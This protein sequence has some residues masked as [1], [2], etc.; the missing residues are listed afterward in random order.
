MDNHAVIVDLD[1][2]LFDCNHRKYLIQGPNPDWDTFFDQARYDTVF[3]YVRN[4][5]VSLQTIGYSML[6]CTSRPENNRPVTEAALRKIAGVS[7]DLLAMRSDSDF[8]PANEVKRDMLGS[9]RK[10]G[11]I[12]IL[13]IED[14]PD[15]VKMWRENGVP[16]LQTPYE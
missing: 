4:T 2:T 11:Y 9:I 14:S 7:W 12:P 8:R 1:G 3:D 6:I 10:M 13:A 5:Y 16:C 15:V